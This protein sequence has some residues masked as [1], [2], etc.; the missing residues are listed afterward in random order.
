MRNDLGRRAHRALLNSPGKSFRNELIG[1]GFLGLLIT[2]G[3]VVC[4][5]QSRVFLRAFSERVSGRWFIAA[6]S[7]LVPEA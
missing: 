4:L 6:R 1:V 7:F 5:P 2:K 3:V